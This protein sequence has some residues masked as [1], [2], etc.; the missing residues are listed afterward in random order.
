MRGVA[1]QDT[2]HGHTL[3]GVAEEFR[4]G[5]SSAAFNLHFTGSRPQSD[6]VYLP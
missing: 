1:D 5:R 2:G 6:F 4:G 3:L